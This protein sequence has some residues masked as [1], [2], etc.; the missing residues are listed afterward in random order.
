M[1]PC[2]EEVTE[3]AALRPVTDAP[4]DRA[5]SGREAPARE[6]RAAEG[7]SKRAGR[8]RLE[9]V[10]AMRPVKQAGVVSTHCLLFFAPSASLAVGACLLFTHVTRFA[11]MFISAAM[12]VYAY[13]EIGRGRIGT[14][15]RR[16]LVRVVL[17]FVTWTV[18]YFLLESLPLSGV[19]GA[20]RPTGGI[21]SSV[22]VSLER[23]GYLLVTGYYQLYYLIVLIEFY[24][25]YPAFLWMIRRTAGHH[26]L[27]FGCSLLVQVLL[28][29]L[30][31]Y[32]VVPEWMRGWAATRELFD[33]QIYLVAGGIMAWHDQA[34]H[35]Y[36][37]T[38]GRLPPRVAG[39]VRSGAENSYGIYLSQVLFITLLSMAGVDRLEH[40]VPW[41]IVLVGSIVVVYAAATALT[42]LLARLPG[43]LATSGRSRQPMPTWLTRAARHVVLVDTPG[44]ARLSGRARARRRRAP[45][46]ARPAGDG[47]RAAPGGAG[48]CGRSLP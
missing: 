36:V 12:L 34:I 41:P 39:W 5:A 32:G 27:L 44:A 18:I 10:D 45:S 8:P 28:V 23:L 25:V 3:R 9:H 17:P 24:L 48:R 1:S 43:A 13:P 37:V 15:W 29:S 46:R 35:D 22:T 42:S 21:A 31:H 16:R 47:H 40:V 2:D 33:Y 38:H 7:P 26:R 20:F 4:G 30:I 6:P 19:P 14:F 11:F